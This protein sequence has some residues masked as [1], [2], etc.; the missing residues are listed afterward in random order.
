MFAFFVL[1]FAI[2]LPLQQLGLNTL[3]VIVNT[4]KLEHG[5]EMI[6]AGLPYTLP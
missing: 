2:D 4:R 6:G 1:L 3:L 5:F